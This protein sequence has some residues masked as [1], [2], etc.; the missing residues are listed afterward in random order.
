[1]GIPSYFRLI[2]QDFPE[3]IKKNIKHITGKQISHLFLDFNCLIH[4]CCSKVLNKYKFERQ[5]SIETLEQKCF[6]EIESYLKVICTFVKPSELL[7]ISIDGPAPAAKM[8]QQ[9]KRRFRS[10]LY[11]QMVEDIDSIYNGKIKNKWDKNAITPGTKFMEDL[12]TFLT[13]R[14]KHSV[15]SSI[16][17]II[18]SDS[19]EPGEGEHKILDYLRNIDSKESDTYVI[20]GLDADLIMLALSSNLPNIYLLREDVAF[21]RVDMNTLLYF[22]ICEFKHKFIDNLLNGY[23]IQFS[24]FLKQHST[25]LIQDY[26][27]LCF[28][29]G[30]DFLPRLS[31]LNI[32]NN[33]LETLLNIYKEILLQ[34]Q[35]F[36]LIDSTI[37]F[38]FLKKIFQNLLKTE[39][40]DMIHIKKKYYSR[41]FHTRDCRDA[42]KIELKKID[43]KPLLER[44]ADFIHP[45]KNGWQRRYYYNFF[46]IQNYKKNTKNIQE[47][48]KNYIQGLAWTTNYYFKG[49]CSWDW[50]YPYSKA[51]LI[52]S[53]LDN[54]EYCLDFTDFTNDTSSPVEPVE[55][56]LCVL[57]PQSK[58]LLP[59]PYRH[60]MESDSN[61]GCYYPL[62]TEYE[63]YLSYYFH[64]CEPNLIPINLTKIK[65]YYNQIK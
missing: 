42:Y 12:S 41:R 36:L 16:P 64:D 13:M 24:Q 65:Y 37:N 44:K 40:S 32:R 4:P 30:N 34:K 57:P 26:I 22:D 58:E 38:P 33:S 19:N 17:N 54:F 10:I 59:S 39:Q 1:M 25:N 51:P 8:L 62:K 35:E 3:L 23:T 7:Y 61:L 31:S 48:C 15:F 46:N 63:S 50:F 20:Y 55:Q 47:I 18:L 49:C 14:L 21:G 5:L 52:E 9:R 27:F 29:I 2:I 53:L 45:E 11:N 43:C 56:L 60:L 28:L 6:D